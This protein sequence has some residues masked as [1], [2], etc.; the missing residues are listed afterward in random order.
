M[1]TSCRACG[2]SQL[3]EVVDLGRQYL[4]DFRDDEQRPPRR[5]LA[6]RLCQVCQLVQLSDTTPRELMYHDGYGFYS[7]VNENIRRD[8]AT[9]VDQGLAWRPHA[10][11]WLDIA[12][13]DGT[14]LSFVPE[15]IYRVG[16]DPVAKFQKLSEQ[17]ADEIIVDYFRPLQWTRP[18]AEI[19]ALTDTRFDVIS[20]I[21][22]FYDLDD[23]NE[24]VHSVRA[25]LADH[26]VWIVQQN[27][28]LAMLEA[29]S[30]DN[31][32]H[33][34]L[35]YWSLGAL[36]R[37]LAEYRLRVI[38]VSTSGVNGG[39]I[40]TV[41]AHERG[42]YL[43]QPSVERQLRI[44][45]AA[46]LGKPGTF[47]AFAA[48]AQGELRKL[49]RLVADT[50]AGGG[51]V[52]ILAASTRGAV[53]WQAAGLDAS[54]ITYAVERNPDKV[55]KMFSALGVPI[56]SEQ[57]AR[58]MQP[59]MMLVG[60]W[61]FREQIIERERSYLQRGGRLVFPLPRLEIVSKPKRGQ[62]VSRLVQ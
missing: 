22:M 12:C 27:Y 19:G 47:R 60:P 61:W 14:L 20:S 56:I 21:S 8:L 4:S 13:N 37:L 33:E 43:E 28:L 54:L 9:V 39:S 5:P 55:G 41:I 53:I 44:E 24:F 46:R 32:C 58:E 17:H 50:V 52:H 45:Q 10:T 15:R 16:V 7:G 3:A 18:R 23:P 35:T 48:R 36:R 29:N 49:H 11:R 62:P 34:H 26:G 40:R 30:I 1:I 51:D 6:L 38:D 59:A 31:V 42:Y 57:V 25:C 2:S